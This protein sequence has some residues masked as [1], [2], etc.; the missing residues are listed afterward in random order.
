MDERI[1]R[2]KS[3]KK[4]YKKFK[5]RQ[6]ALWRILWWILSVFGVMGLGMWLYARFYKF[7][8]F[9]LLDLNLWEPTKAA[10][11]LP[12]DLSMVGAAV[13]QFAPLAL[14][15]ILVLWLLCWILWL[16]KS[17]DSRKSPEF[18]DYQTLRF[19]LKDEAR[20]R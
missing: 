4:T 19:A 8:L 18:L 5:R 14:V 13:K 2:L 6:T 17:R 16:K 3:L 7:P 1:L 20:E 11:G 15:G 9:R 12:Q 10:L